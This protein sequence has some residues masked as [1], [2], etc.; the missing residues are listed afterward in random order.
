MSIIYCCP[1]TGTASGSQFQSFKSNI[2][3]AE[4]F[5]SEMK[6]LNFG[7]SKEVIRNISGCGSPLVDIDNISFVR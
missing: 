2:E 4:P 3:A 6:K 1:A 7:A 5:K